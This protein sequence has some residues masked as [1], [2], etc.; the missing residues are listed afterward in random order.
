M[1]RNTCSGSEGSSPLQLSVPH[2]ASSASSSSSLVTKIE[3]DDEDENELR[4]AGFMASRRIEK[5]AGATPMSLIHTQ[6]FSQRLSWNR[7]SLSPSQ[8]GQG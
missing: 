6:H 4:P 8:R 5:T 7:V 1:K 2:S 3:D